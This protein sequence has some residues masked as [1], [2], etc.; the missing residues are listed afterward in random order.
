MKLAALAL[1]ITTL[2]TGCASTGQKEVIGG[3]LGAAGGGLLGSQFGGGTGQ[4][5][6]TALGAVGGFLLGSSIGRSLDDLDRLK[7][8]RAV[9]SALETLPSGA[10]AT[11][12]NPDSGNSGYVM[13]TL[14]Y[15]RTDGAYCRQFTQTVSVRGKTEK[16]YGTA[17][18]QSDGSWEIVS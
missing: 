1:T 5:A 16:T 11:W 12:R 6:L 18:R 4:L 8:Q 9:S 7:H 17:C 14:T 3:V 10:S 15:Q 13:P 2:L